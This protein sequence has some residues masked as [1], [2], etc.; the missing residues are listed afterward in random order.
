M[1]CTLSPFSRRR[2][3]AEPVLFHTRAELCLRRRSTA[4]WGC[5]THVLGPRG[6]VWSRT[7]TL[8]A[9]LGPTTPSSRSRPLWPLQELRAAAVVPAAWCCVRTKLC[10]VLKAVRYRKSAVPGRASQNRTAE[11]A[12]VLTAHLAQHGRGTEPH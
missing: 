9:P 7:A 10:N 6:P 3:R 1:L 4:T 11:P 8:R 5:R 2:A 12:C